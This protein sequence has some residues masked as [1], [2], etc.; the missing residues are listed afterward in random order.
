MSVNN[1]TEPIKKNKLAWKFPPYSK[2]YKCLQHVINQIAS[3]RFKKSVCLTFE[4][5]VIGWIFTLSFGQ[6]KLE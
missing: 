3:M 4:V 2:E 6:W 1:R 5:T